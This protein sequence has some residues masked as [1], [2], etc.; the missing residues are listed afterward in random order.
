MI[1]KKKMS[2][3]APASN[4]ADLGIMQKTN[5]LIIRETNEGDVIFFTQLFSTFYFIL[6]NY[7]KLIWVQIWVPYDSSN[8]DKIH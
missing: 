4:V 8:L 3:I 1:E 2:K 5:L 6:K 7:R